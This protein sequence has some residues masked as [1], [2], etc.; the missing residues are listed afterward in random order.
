MVQKICNNNIDDALKS[1][2]A[3]IYFTAKQCNPCKMLAPVIKELSDELCGKVD[4]FNA[5]SE[6]NSELA[7]EYQINSVPTI[8]LFKNGEVI[9]KAV[10]FKSKDEIKSMI[11]SKCG[12]CCK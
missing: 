4:F 7:Q 12:C 6:E 1:K 11:K 10:G 2:L 9:D 8:L 5:D 3:L